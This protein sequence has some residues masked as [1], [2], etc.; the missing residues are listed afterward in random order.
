[1]TMAKTRMTKWERGK[2]AN[3]LYDDDVKKIWFHLD[4]IRMEGKLLGIVA[5][6]ITKERIKCFKNV[7]DSI[8]KGREAQYN[9]RTNEMLLSPQIT[10][11]N[12]NV[13]MESIII[14]ESVHALIDYKKMSGTTFFHNEAV[15][16]V[17][18]GLFLRNKS[19]RWP[20]ALRNDPI[21]KALEALIDKYKMTENKAWLKWVHFEPLMRAIQSHRIYRLPDRTKLP[22]DIKTPADGIAKAGS[23]AGLINQRA[24]A[25]NQR[26]PM[27]HAS[28]KKVDGSRSR[29]PL[30]IA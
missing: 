14:H 19:T 9:N 17:T 15:A 11:N 3:A 4:Q 13:L 29:T 18:Q 8:L 6:L 7:P 27:G 1:M 10:V 2:L 5:N 20:A 30:G 28:G 22:W 23:P 16:Y 12:L 26:G 21:I 25:A 24:L